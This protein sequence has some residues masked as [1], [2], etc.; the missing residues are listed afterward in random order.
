MRGTHTGTDAPLLG[1][2]NG[3]P[4]GRHLQCIKRVGGNVTL[5]SKSYGT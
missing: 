2:L 3:C 1:G 5:V 4:E